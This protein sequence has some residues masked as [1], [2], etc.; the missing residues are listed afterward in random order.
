MMWDGFLW[1][2]YLQA[3]AQCIAR[4]WAEWR[5]GISI[6]RH[7]RAITAFFVQRRTDKQLRSVSGILAIGFFRVFSAGG[8]GS[9]HLDALQDK[10]S[11]MAMI[12][13]QTEANFWLA[14]PPL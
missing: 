14:S 12:A 4:S 7:I 3:C 2:I 6:R 9:P 8:E 1:S 5:S 13:I 10:Y 11:S